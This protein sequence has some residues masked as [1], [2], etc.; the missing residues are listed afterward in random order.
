MPTRRDLA[1]ILYIL[2]DIR[3]GN[4]NQQV[5][6]LASHLPERAL[7]SRRVRT[8][9]ARH[10]SSDHLQLQVR[11]PGEQNAYHFADCIN[12]ERFVLNLT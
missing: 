10:Q 8:F 1:I 5:D 3:K 11:L 9:N 7:D 2:R 12:S 6:T 4:S